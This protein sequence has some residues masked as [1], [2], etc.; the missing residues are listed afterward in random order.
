MMECDVQAVFALKSQI[1]LKISTKKLPE[2]FV[3]AVH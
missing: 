3:A 2:I 1:P